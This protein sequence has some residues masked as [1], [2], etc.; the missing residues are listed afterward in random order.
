M[1]PELAAR[2]QQ[3]LDGSGNLLFIF[4]DKRDKKVPYDLTPSL[5]EG[6]LQARLPWSRNWAR[7]H[8]RSELTTHSVNPELIDGWMGHEE[9][10]EE[11]LGR[12]S[13][14]SMADCREIADIIESI[15]VNNKIKVLTGWTTH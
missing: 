3:A 2:C 9:I 7:H 14:L 4:T 13:F 1:E 15:F 8:L 5:L 12:H 10:G 6:L 11:V